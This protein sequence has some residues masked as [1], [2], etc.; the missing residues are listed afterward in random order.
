MYNMTDKPIID[1]CRMSFV[2]LAVD[3]QPIETLDKM[4]HA[5]IINYLTM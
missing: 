5:K 2:T 4:F 3:E 1:A